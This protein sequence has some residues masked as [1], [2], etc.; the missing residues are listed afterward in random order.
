MGQ[1]LHPNCT[2]TKP[3][4]IDPD[5]GLTVSTIMMATAITGCIML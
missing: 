1:D 5:T 4:G 2:E 3:I